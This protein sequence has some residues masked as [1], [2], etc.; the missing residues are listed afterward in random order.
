M[1]GFVCLY[2]YRSIQTYMHTYTQHI[3]PAPHACEDIGPQHTE[4]T[5]QD[6]QHPALV[7][8]P[9]APFWEN[10]TE[11]VCHGDVRSTKA[12]FPV[13]RLYLIPH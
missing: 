13:T 6:S 1:L 11:T 4:V 9:G 2:T 5:T 7:P 10:A 3:P 8:Y 12:L